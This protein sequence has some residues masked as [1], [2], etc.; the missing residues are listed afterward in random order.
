MWAVSSTPHSPLPSMS[1]GVGG[2]GWVGAFRESL[3]HSSKTI[4]LRQQ[5]QPT[6][7]QVL[8]PEPRQLFRIT[9]VDEEVTLSPVSEGRRRGDRDPHP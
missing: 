8:S 9:V 7:P 2:V 4:D 1:L 6:F 3:E 5:S